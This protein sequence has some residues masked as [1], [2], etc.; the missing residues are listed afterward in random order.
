MFIIAL[1]APFV[2]RADVT[3]ESATSTGVIAKITPAATD[4]GI[5]NVYIGAE[6]GGSLYLRGLS[7]SDWKLYDPGSPLPVAAY[8][9]TGSTVPSVTVQVSDMDI[10]ALVG[11]NVYVAYGSSESEALNSAGHL[12]KIYT[13]PEPTPTPQSIPP[14]IQMGVWVEGANQLPAGCTSSA[15]PC[16]RNALS[17]GL[18]KLI[19]T[20]ATMTGYSGRTVVF[21]FYRSA[22]GLWNILPI[23]ADDFSPVGFGIDGGMYS[24][25][26]KVYGNGSGIIIHHADNICTQQS[27]YEQSRNWGYRIASCP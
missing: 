23:Y 8:I 10:S 15:Q 14:P 18:V 21:A 17:S 16:W 12:A 13:V 25:I 26:D 1:V 22:D 3:L 6:I 24:V 4:S 19:A 5:K 9:V 27:W 2:C 7:I 11:L 20:S